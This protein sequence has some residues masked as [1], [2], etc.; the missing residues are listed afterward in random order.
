MAAH[1]LGVCA[2]T[3]R[4]LG[5]APLNIGRRVLWDRRSLDL[6]VDR[7][8]GAPLSEDELERAAADQERAMLARLTGG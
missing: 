2:A 1:Y 8:A 7:M 4:T 6:Y 3:F 5:I